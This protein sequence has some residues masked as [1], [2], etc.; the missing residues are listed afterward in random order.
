[1]L[2]Q[3]ARTDPAATGSN[4]ERRDA[5][6]G[7]SNDDPVG[8]DLAARRAPTT[9]GW[10][11]QRAAR[12]AHCLYRR[13]PSDAGEGSFGT[14]RSGS[15]AGMPS[16]AAGSFRLDPVVG[17]QTLKA[18]YSIRCCGAFRLPAQHQ[19]GNGKNSSRV[20]DCASLPQSA[21]ARPDTATRSASSSRPRS[22]DGGSLTRR[23]GHLPGRCRSRAA[24]RLRVRLPRAGT[25]ARRLAKTSL[26][27]RAFQGHRTRLTRLLR[28]RTGRST[29]RSSAKTSTGCDRRRQVWHGP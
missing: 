16:N 4:R 7:E 21:G 14:G 13:H 11:T 24:F 12:T 25:T 18:E 3:P 10:P 26:P 29:A 1:M 22:C 23:G 17:G 19:G 2:Q 27:G 5:G 28:W 8:S 6:G 20:Q 9:A 15:A